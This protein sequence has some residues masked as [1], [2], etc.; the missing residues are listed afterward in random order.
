M[1]GNGAWGIDTIAISK[2]LKRAGP[3]WADG[4][5]MTLD[6]IHMHRVVGPQYTY[7]WGWLKPNTLTW[8]PWEFRGKP[9][10]EGRIALG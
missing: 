5:G 9:P 1:N 7:T 3:C 4:A 6:L 8:I 10:A 2:I